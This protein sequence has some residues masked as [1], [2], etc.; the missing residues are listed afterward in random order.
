MLFLKI[1]KQ[2][3]IEGDLVKV[4][5][6]EGKVTNSN[7]STRGPPGSNTVSIS[8]ED[9]FQTALKI[10]ELSEESLDIF[11]TSK[12]LSYEEDRYA[13]SKQNKGN[14][15]NNSVTSPDRGQSN[16]RDAIKPAAAA[17]P[18]PALA[19]VSLS[20]SDLNEFTDDDIDYRFFETE[21]FDPILDPCARFGPLNLSCSS[22]LKQEQKQQL[23]QQEK[24][25]PKPARRA[26]NSQKLATMTQP[27]VDYVS[28]IE[29]SVGPRLSNP[30][31][32]SSFTECPMR[33]PIHVPLPRPLPPPF[34]IGLPPSKP[35]GCNFPS[36]NMRSGYNMYKYYNGVTPAERERMEKA[37]TQRVTAKVAGSIKDAMDK[38]IQGTIGANTMGGFLDLTPSIPSS[39]EKLPQSTASTGKT[40]ISN[41]DEREHSSIGIQT[42]DLASPWNKVE[43]THILCDNCDS[44]VIGFRYK[45][46]VCRDYDLCSKCEAI[47]PPVHNEDHP[48]TKYRK[49][50]VQSRQPKISVSLSKSPETVLNLSRLSNVDDPIFTSNDFTAALREAIYDGLAKK[51]SSSK[52]TPKEASEEISKDGQK[53]PTIET[54]KPCIKPLKPATFVSLGCSQKMRSKMERVKSKLS[55]SKYAILEKND[56]E[57]WKNDKFE[58]ANDVLLGVISKSV[59]QPQGEQST[60]SLMMAKPSACGYSDLAEKMYSSRALRRG[61]SISGKSFLAA[62][63]VQ[64]HGIPDG[65]PVTPGSI[66]SRS[67]EIQNIG[68]KTWTK[69]V[70]LKYIWGNELLETASTLKEIPVP[71]LKPYETGVVSLTFKAPT[72]CAFGRYTSQWRLHHKGESF[73]PRFECSIVLDPAAAPKFVAP[74]EPP[75]PLVSYPDS[76]HELKEF[77][78]GLKERMQSVQKLPGF[79]RIDAAFAKV[80]DKRIAR[81]EV[82]PLTG[83]YIVEDLTIQNLT[84]GD[85]APAA[86]KSSNESNEEPQKEEV[87]NG[88]SVSE[89]AQ[90]SSL[91]SSK[92]S[93]V[94]SSSEEKSAGEFVMLTPCIDL[95]MP[96]SMDS[97]KSSLSNSTKELDEKVEN[98]T[99]N[100][101]QPAAAASGMSAPKTVDD[102]EKQDDTSDDDDFDL[103]ADSSSDFEH[104][105]DDDSAIQRFEDMMRNTL[106]TSTSE[107]ADEF[108]ETI[109]A[110]PINADLLTKES[111]SGSSLNLDPYAYQPLP[112]ND[113]NSLAT[114]DD[115]CVFL[116]SL[117]TIQAKSPGTV[118]SKESNENNIVIDAKKSP[119]V[120][121]EASK[122][123][124]VKPSAPFEVPIEKADDLAGVN[125]PLLMPTRYNGPGIQ[126]QVRSNNSA[127]IHVL[128]EVIVNSAVNA[129][130]Q[131]VNNVSRVLQNVVPPN[132]FGPSSTDARDVESGAT[133]SVPVGEDKGNNDFK[134]CNAMLKLF[135]MGF[136]D[137]KLNTQLLEEN[138]M[139]IANTIEALLKKM[140]VVEDQP[141]NQLNGPFIEF[142]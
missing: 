127:V 104:L 77:E 99:N 12:K 54:N 139:N 87:K 103:L 96:L 17:A 70:T 10:A 73:G 67:W 63:I 123:A 75:S 26:V 52:N 13:C 8:C 94:A 138:E 72:G 58:D 69:R 79:R 65:T 27:K 76:L 61:R 57:N 110:G 120:V 111:S 9:D 53:Q 92:H 66:F 141:K 6:F 117:N 22:P 129:A 128:P 140:T 136:W 81:D 34:K 48:F 46:T 137:D 132:S 41:D 30:E 18:P 119:E 125:E 112:T 45:C 29:G 15:I 33:P 107:S 36:Y 3:C 42:A 84:T 47:Y 97:F 49:P 64:D 78:A 50:V 118:A 114:T 106:S 105:T 23:Q 14:Q 100:A 37:I 101:S 116:P 90:I 109:S 40:N 56:C 16:Q 44:T 86:T 95:H 130:S 43:H 124:P 91:N 93:D 71:R 108:E 142:D 4:L 20:N 51:P 82:D 98:V 134:R 5:K 102:K 122:V 113:P 121:L 62:A 1:C 2:N 31:A 21:I 80:N 88:T 89:V 115:S 133:A 38:I 19:T 85:A 32:K 24:N 74:E 35:T 59:V 28:L 83:E 60:S 7:G 126:Q 135:E 68:T 131:M 11:A 39:P 25:H 55:S